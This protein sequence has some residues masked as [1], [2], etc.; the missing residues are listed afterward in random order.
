M[1]FL[2]ILLYAEQTTVPDFAMLIYFVRV[3][4]AAFAAGAV[5]VVVSW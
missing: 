2:H 3:L 5:D 1:A 4:N